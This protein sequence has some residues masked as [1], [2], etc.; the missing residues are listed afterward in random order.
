M[1]GAMTTA[2]AVVVLLQKLGHETQ[3]LTGREF[4]VPAA[5]GASYQY[6]WRLLTVQARARILQAA[7]PDWHPQQAQRHVGEELK[8]LERSAARGS[9]YA[10]S[11]LCAIEEALCHSAVAPEAQAERQALPAP[12]FDSHEYMRRYAADMAEFGLN[13]PVYDKV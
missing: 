4:S 12:G 9:S 8:W 1:V 6:R 3:P 5:C 2:A 7:F 10:R 13:I 11:I